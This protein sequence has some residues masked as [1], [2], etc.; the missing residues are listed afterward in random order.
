M[1]LILAAFMLSMLSIAPAHARVLSVDFEYVADDRLDFYLN[2]Q[3]IEMAGSNDWTYY[4]VLSSIDGSLPMDA[5]KWGQKNLI[6]LNNFDTLAGALDCSWRLSVRYSDRPPFV[7][8]ATSENTRMLRRTRNQ[9]APT[10]WEQV[11]FDDKV[12][13]A[14][15]EALKAKPLLV[16]LPMNPAEQQL[17]H[18]DILPR[19]CATADCECSVKDNNLLRT[20]FELPAL[21]EGPALTVA[22]KALEKND[23][24]GLRL[25]WG[26][27][28]GELGARLLSLDVPKGLAVA[29]VSPGAEVKGRTLEWR[30]PA[31][32]S[33]GQ[34][35]RLLLQKVEDAGGWQDADKVLQRPFQKFMNPIGASVP[36]ATFLPDQKAWFKV[37][38]RD[39]RQRQLGPIQGVLFRAQ[40]DFEE[41]N[42]VSSTTVVLDDRF[43]LN[44][45]VDGRLNGVL[46]ADQNMLHALSLPLWTQA[47]YDA[48]ADRAWTWNELD[49][50][51]VQLM[52][53]RKIN[54]SVSWKMTAFEVWVRSAPR[55]PEAWAWL[56]HDGSASGVVQL[57]ASVPLSQGN[58]LESNLVQVQ[59]NP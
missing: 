40:I 22:P 36:M 2:G 6:A 24:T 56:R 27:D 1:K 10:G 8:I 44:Y 26:A 52:S 30:A 46:A 51:K 37:D 18:R 25:R 55:L 45:S 41:Y 48:S 13:E 57:K 54:K 58:S 4:S 9:S 33:A 31:T 15:D 21:P 29:S 50:L 5:F 53:K 34:S 3:K 14:P 47:Y 38:V 59:L 12:W 19:L 17:F 23:K 43:T 11:A 7:F 20:W 32:G 49:N 42:F 35:T 16:W 39:P 28:V